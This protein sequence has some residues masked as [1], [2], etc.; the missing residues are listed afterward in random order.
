M[1]NNNTNI[2]IVP[3]TVLSS[4]CEMRKR[5][6]SLSNLFK[7]TK[8]LSGKAR[9]WISVIWSQDMCFYTLWDTV[10]RVLEEKGY[11]LQII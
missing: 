1:S 8:L 2:Y 5:A 3:D 4:L 11:Y 7:V 9:I 10:S 6:W